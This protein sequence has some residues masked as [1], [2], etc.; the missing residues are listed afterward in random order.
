MPKNKLQRSMQDAFRLS[1]KT[2]QTFFD[3]HGRNL[4]GSHVSAVNSTVT[5]DLE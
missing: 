2:Q 1:K 5:N 3:T 4:I